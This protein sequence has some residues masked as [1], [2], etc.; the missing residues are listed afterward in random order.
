[1]EL[2]VPSTGWQPTYLELITVII[3]DNG[4]DGDDDDGGFAVRQIRLSLLY[5]CVQKSSQGVSSRSLIE[6]V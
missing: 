6:K 2:E 4:G 1:L 5:E 3:I